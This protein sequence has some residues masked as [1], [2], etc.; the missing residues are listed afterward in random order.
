MGGRWDYAD[1]P[2]K[3]HTAREGDTQT[4]KGLKKGLIGA[5]SGRRSREV[6]KRSRESKGKEK[7][8]RR[9]GPTR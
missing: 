5:R 4:E 8:P 7:G 1:R 9:G 6:D 3:G 2:D